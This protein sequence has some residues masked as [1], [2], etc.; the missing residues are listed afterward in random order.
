MK[1]WQTPAF[2][3]LLNIAL[4]EDLD[5]GDATSQALILPSAVNEA[6]ILTKSTCIVAGQW[7]AQAVF[8][9][10]DRTL[11][12]RILIEDGQK[13]HKGCII[14][15]VKGN[16][17]SILAGERLAL[18]FLQRLS[19]IAT[20]THDLVTRIGSSACKVVDT[21]KTAP[22]MRQL[23]K[24]AVRTGGGFN[25]RMNLGDGILIKDNHI[26]ACSG[27]SNAVSA[28]RKNACHTLKIQVEV[29]TMIEAEEAAACGADSL[30]LDNMTPDL[31]HQIVERFGS[32]LLLECSGNLSG[33]NIREYSNTGVHILS[34][35][36]LTHSVHAADISLN[37][38]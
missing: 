4:A 19:G 30:L 1:P 25:H 20:S 31:V 9:N 29:T 13:S 37:L 10:V 22:G 35:G 28:A 23:D 24:Y 12:Y 32:S 2:K 18:N 3:A 8:S 26:K 17:A 34:V 21:R 6:E 11:E 36:A 27:I 14:A 7:V 38:R 16:T 5:S 15:T 33:D